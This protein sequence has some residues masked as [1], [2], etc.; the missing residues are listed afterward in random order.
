MSRASLN[1]PMKSS[2]EQSYRAFPQGTIHFDSPRAWDALI[3]NGFCYTL[4]HYRDNAPEEQRVRILRKSRDTGLRASKNLIFT[5]TNEEFSC[6]EGYVSR[7]GFSSVEEWLA[8][9]ETLSGKSNRWQ[10]FC[11]DLDDPSRNITKQLYQEQAPIVSRHASL[12]AGTRLLDDF[13]EREDA[14]F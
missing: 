12:K 11:V 9:A 6:L 13:N 7:S 2:R 8:E 14:Q 10:L 3:G 5:I 4:R 1:L